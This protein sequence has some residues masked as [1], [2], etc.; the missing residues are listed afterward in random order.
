MKTAILLASMLAIVTAVL[1]TFTVL[2]I[3]HHAPT[4]LIVGATFLTALSAYMTVFMP[5]G[6]YLSTRKT[7]K[8]N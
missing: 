7:E 3:Q 2:A 1:F 8:F 5:C 6:Y 4:P